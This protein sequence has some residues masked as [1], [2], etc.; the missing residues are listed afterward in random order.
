MSPR[1]SLVLASLRALGA[2]VLLAG[3]AACAG[4]A[5]DGQA[6]VPVATPTSDEPPDNTDDTGTLDIFCNPPTKVL[7]DGKPAGTTPVTGYKVKPGSHDVTFAD[8]QTGN[9]TMTVT[10]ATGE[11]KTLT[12]DRPPS[13]QQVLHKDDPADKKK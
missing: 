8:E 13:M 6:A 10:V 4:A 7:V 9:R 1:P 3:V 12:S 11:G 5:K 2:A